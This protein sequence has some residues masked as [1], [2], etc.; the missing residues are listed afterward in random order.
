MGMR[1]SGVA[2][3]L[4]A[5]VTAACPYDHLL[6]SNGGVAIGG[7]GGG[8]TRPHPLAFTVQPSKATP[9]NII[10]PPIQVLVPDSLGLP[11]SSFSGSINTCMHL[12]ALGG[13][14]S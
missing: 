8:G 10:T 11:D 5:L 2:I 3:A 12:N 1:L 6:T 4:A 13:P 14:L 9:G 7:G